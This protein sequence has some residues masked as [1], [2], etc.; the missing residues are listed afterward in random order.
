MFYQRRNNIDR[1]HE[2]C[3]YVQQLTITLTLINMETLNMSDYITAIK[4]TV[5]HVY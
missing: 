4:W 2:I 5:T 3:L 1:G